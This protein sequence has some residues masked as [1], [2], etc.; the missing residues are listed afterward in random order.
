MSEDK[1]NPKL[2]K[3]ALQTLAMSY[4]YYGAPARVSGVE[5]CSHRTKACTELCLNTSGN[6]RYAATQIYRIARTRLEVYRRAEFWSMFSAELQKA[7]RKQRKSGKD[8][9]AIRPNGTTV[10][11]CPELS[12]MC[13]DNRDVRFYDYTAVPSRLA[14]ADS[15]PNYDVTLSRKETKS[16]H[17]WLR[18]EGYGKRNVAVVVTPE[19]KFELLNAGR[20]CGI[21]LVDFDAHDLRI[22][23]YDGRGVI[24]LLTP[25]G[26]ARGKD[27]GFIVTDRAQLESEITG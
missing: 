1:T 2:L 24:G 8:F 15:I 6:G 22:P 13:A 19:L 12:A 20:I 18:A 16:N 5:M 27:S 7:K 10:R 26:K 3:S 21:P 25:K 14:I 17:A 9:L 4:I 11:W 23:E